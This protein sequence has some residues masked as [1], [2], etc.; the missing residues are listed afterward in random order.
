MIT[1]VFKTNKGTL[2]SGFSGNNET[3]FYDPEIEK[4]FK[5]G[6]ST[7]DREERI[8]IY[9]EIVEKIHFGEIPA[10]VLQSMPRY[11]GAS[12][13]VSDLLLGPRGG[14]YMLGRWEFKD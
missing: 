13:K 8:G 1:N 2:D 14:P 3:R 6:L 9:K 5:A 7:L 10:I 4:L 11:M 12:Y